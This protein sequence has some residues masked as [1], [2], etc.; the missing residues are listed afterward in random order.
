MDKS[1]IKTFAM[2]AR[3]KLIENITQN[4]FEL[5]ITKNKII[6]PEVFQGGFRVGMHVFKSYQKKQYDRL[7]DEIREKGFEQVIE[8]T[9]YTWF[10]RLIA[11]RFMEV[12]EFLPIGIRILSSQIEE[13][14]EPDI[15]QE[16][17]NVIEDLELDIEL[18]YSLQDENKTE[19]LFKY[20]LVKQCNKLNEILPYMFEKIED[21]T[22][23]LLPNQ[24]LKDGSVVRELVTSIPEDAWKEQVEIIGWLYQYYISEK[25]DEVFTELK[26]N[27]K[28]TKES[29]PA[30]TQLFTP[31]WIVKYMVENSLGRLW[32]ESH[33]NEEL[34]QQWKYY[35]E[36]AEQEP[37]GIEQLEKPKNKELSP[38]EIKVL[39]PCMGS[40]HIL[41]YAFDLL[42]QIY[43]D[44]GYAERDIPILII[45]KNLYGLDIDD[46][47]AQLAYFA[48]MMKARSYDRRIF[49]KRLTPN[50]VAIQE[51]NGILQ[52]AIKYFMNDLSCSDDLKYLLK[53]FQN[54]KE[55]GSII[56]V[57]PINF[58][59]LEEVLLDLKEDESVSNMFYL[60]YRDIILER[61][62]L[63]IKQAKLLSMKYDVVIT[64]PPYMGRNGMNSKLMKFTDDYYPQSKGDMFAVFIEKASK[65]IKKNMYIS[66]VTMHS[67]MY[68]P[69]FNELRTQLFG[70]NRFSSLVH[71]GSRAFEELKGEKVQ[72]IAFVLQRMNALQNV[73]TFIK[74]LDYN[75][76]EFKEREFFNKENYF[77]NINQGYILNSPKGIP[78]YEIT[79]TVDTII[80]TYRP[81]SEKT[82]VK[83]CLATGKDEWFVR[84]WY[85]V[86]AEKIKFPQKKEQNKWYPVVNGGNYQKW[87]GNNNYILNWENNGEMIKKLHTEG[88]INATL[89]N[90]DYFFRN[91]LTYTYTSMGSGKFNVR[92]IGTGYTSLGVGP[93][94]TISNDNI[95]LLGYLNST[96]FSYLYRLMF[97]KTSTFETGKIGSVPIPKLTDTLSIGN[98]TKE[99]IE[100]TRLNWN[101]YETSW[102]FKNHPLLVFKN[103]G[104]SIVDAFESWKKFNSEQIQKLKNLECD[105]NNYFIEY[106]NLKKEVD[107]KIEFEDITLFRSNK[108]G[109]IKSFIS[110]AVGCMFGRY[111][112]NQDG[113]IFA[114]GEFSEAL[115]G[116]FKLVK[117]NIIP[118]TD[119]EYFEDDIVSYFIE[120]VGLTFSAEKLEENLDFIAEALGSK[121]NETSRQTIRRYFLNDFYKEHVQ[122]YK[123]HPIYWLFESGKQNGCKALVYMH[124]FDEG[125]VA[126]VRTDYLHPLQRKYEAETARQDMISESSV[127]AREKTEAK[128]KKEKLQKQL[129]ECAEYDQVIAHVANQRIKIDLDDGL[130]VNYIK[131][132]NVEVPQGEG[133][134]PLKAN[135]LSPIKF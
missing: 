21:F 121:G 64:N 132:Q 59:A 128:K 54:A 125:T 92:Y 36:E 115:Y 90:L 22:E 71:L 84:F 58:K 126:R 130:K 10:N 3:I 20:I 69:L 73:P 6:E 94:I 2:S 45:E 12:N 25:K 95:W 107:N 41:V 1:A 28:I 79:E 87:Y 67:W 103:K 24:L 124:R 93:I 34:R 16:V 74:L 108:V 77:T 76:F 5:G 13:K 33:P 39:D 104:E 7:I 46:R 19:E 134:K 18:V 116:T 120:F 106:F 61:I 101:S 26:K 111:S 50:L 88:K 55:Y 113:L 86:N 131:F 129:I 9:A 78:T 47:A 135:L 27:K 98:L 17:T 82:D 112:L 100:I 97:G 53:V 42:F 122:T 123:K 109:D 70:N 127:S 40:G 89:R 52:E 57:H 4:A 44:A 114:G 91:S 83:R 102:D 110:Y 56:D 8:E 80:K 99:C 38:E 29:I 23:L 30:A 65:L 81:L 43:K 75:K 60:E 37:E 85:E 105:I 66:M 14:S 48:V 51:S 11:L 35:V 117:D 63:L 31:K 32:L 15:I 62:P 68:L 72:A 118:I 119:D 133:K 49:S 96:T